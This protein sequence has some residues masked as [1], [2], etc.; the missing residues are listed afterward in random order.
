MLSTICFS[1]SAVCHLLCS[2]S[3]LSG[4]FPFPPYCR[5]LFQTEQDESNIEM[6]RD[7]K[8]EDRRKDDSEGGRKEEKEREKDRDRK[9]KRER[10]RGR[11]ME[12]D[13]NQREERTERK[14]RSVYVSDF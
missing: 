8:G 13:M 11:Q 9:T 14:E 7:A 5:I 12:R 1:V 10:K 2:D 4:V 6:K 3:V